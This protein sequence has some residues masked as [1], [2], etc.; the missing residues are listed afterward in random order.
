MD[1]ASKKLE[2]IEWVLHQDEAGLN[3]ILNLKKDLEKEVVA[4]DANG[5]ALT[6]EQ[7]KLKADRGLLDFNEG[8]FMSEDDL[9]KEMKN[10]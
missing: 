9:L 10:W 5:N 4:Y 8:R 7:Y 2:L 3:A 1:I 6:L